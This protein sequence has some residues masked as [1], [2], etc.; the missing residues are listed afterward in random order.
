MSTTFFNYSPLP[1]FSNSH[2]QSST[3]IHQISILSSHLKCIKHISTAK[4]HFVSFVHRS[5]KIQE[6]PVTVKT[7]FKLFSSHHNPK[8]TG[9]I[10]SPYRTIRTAYKSSWAV[11][12][13]SFRLFPSVNPGGST[14]HPAMRA[15]GC[16]PCWNYFPLPLPSHSQTQPS[17][18]SIQ[19]IHTN[20]TCH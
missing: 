6:D 19:K 5:N 11:L 8:F 14:S 2:N 17:L 20:N 18:L 10:H 1:N 9:A 13:P 16:E 3:R 12:T 15:M 7:F 4:P